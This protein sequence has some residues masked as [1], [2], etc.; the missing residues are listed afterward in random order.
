MCRKLWPLC[1]PAGECRDST[2]YC[3][4]VRQLELC[5]LPQFKSRCCHSCRNTWGGQV[6]R[7]PWTI[8]IG[9]GRRSDSQRR[10]ETSMPRPYT[11]TCVQRS[12]LDGDIPERGGLFGWSYLEWLWS[13]LLK[14]IMC[15]FEFERCE[16]SDMSVNEGF[17]LTSAFFL[18]PEAHADCFPKLCKV[19]KIT[20]PLWVIETCGDHKGELIK[21]HNNSD[22]QW[23][24]HIW[25]SFRGFLQ[26]WNNSAAPPCSLHVQNIVHII[27]QLSLHYTNM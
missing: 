16:G 20:F 11:H 23:P 18:N 27:M 10:L 2:R 6:R 8:W 15:G 13:A 19:T 22:K 21:K 17:S 14:D 1:I 9:Q 3:E 24:V 4:K 12:V 5:P 26:Q 7:G 25:C